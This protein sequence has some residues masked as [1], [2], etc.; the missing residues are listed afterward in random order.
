MTDELQATHGEKA[1][2]LTIGPAG[3][4]LSKIAAIMNCKDRAA[5][6]SGVGAVMGSKNLK[7]IVVKG[8]NK[9]G[10]KDPDAL[11]AVFKR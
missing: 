5:G 3:E 4:K 7:A 1:K 8:S 11:K 9:V 6:R 10:I 2:V